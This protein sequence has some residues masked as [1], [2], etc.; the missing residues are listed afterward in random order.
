MRF[1][2]ALLAHDLIDETQSFEIVPEM[3]Y[4]KTQFPGGLNCQHTRPLIRDAI[5]VVEYDPNQIEET[6]AQSFSGL[7]ITVK[8]GGRI[9]IPTASEWLDYQLNPAQYLGDLRVVFAKKANLLG[10]TVRSLENAESYQTLKG[11]SPFTSLKFS[12]F[13]PIK[14]QVSPAVADSVGTASAAGGGAKE[15]S[16]AEASYPAGILSFNLAFKVEVG[17]A[18]D[19]SLGQWI[20]SCR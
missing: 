19:G 2:N 8:A 16:V 3:I 20:N 7:P 17:R 14:S 15:E 12:G 11:I 10:D 18:S 13:L 9:A 4:Q 1:W 6:L 5:L